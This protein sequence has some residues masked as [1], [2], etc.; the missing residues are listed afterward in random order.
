MAEE[1]SNNQKEEKKVKKAEIGDT[2]EIKKGEEQGRKGKVIV[3]R[4]N[5]V[6]VEIG[7][8]LKTD[9]PIKTVVNH[10]HYKIVK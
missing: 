2:V 8:N 4:D 9:E 3:V 10:K 5:S 6:I 7:I 1:K